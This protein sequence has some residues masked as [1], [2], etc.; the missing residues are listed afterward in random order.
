MLTRMQKDAKAWAIVPQNIKQGVITWPSN[1]TP[2]YILKS[3][4]NIY[5]NKDLNISVHSKATHNG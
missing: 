1:S 5:A 2:K 3:N 4:E